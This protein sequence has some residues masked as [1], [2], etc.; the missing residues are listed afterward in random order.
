MDSLLRSLEANEEEGMKTLNAILAK[1]EAS[2]NNVHLLEGK[3]YL[4]NELGRE[5]EALKTYLSMMNP[6]LK[7]KVFEYLEFNL[8]QTPALR[9]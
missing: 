1:L 9:Q 6:M 3:C 4:L 7:N 2:L 5:A 8:H